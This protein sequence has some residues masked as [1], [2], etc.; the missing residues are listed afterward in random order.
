L[1]KQ[2]ELLHNRQCKGQSN[3]SLEKFSA[4]Y[5]NAYVTMRQSAAHV[6]FQL[7]NKRTRVTYLLDAIQNSDPGLQAAMAQVRTDTD[8]NTDRMNDFEATA[9]SLL[10]YDPVSKKRAAGVKR[11]M[12]DI[13]STT[14][15]EAEISSF[16]SSAKVTSGKSG[17]EFR[18]YKSPEYQLLLPDQKKELKE[19]R[20]AQKLAGT[21]N[22]GGG[23]AKKPKNNSKQHKQWIASAVKAA[24][25]KNKADATVD[26][27]AESDFKNYIWSLMASK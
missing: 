26:N 6:T 3:F 24:L 1:T 16:K 8:L 21:H 9:S 14:G 10:P 22:Q 18:F 17:V 25:E 23:S 20:D 11:G 4:Q 13:S 12:S 5:R 2:D 15:V 19:W 7:P 27:A